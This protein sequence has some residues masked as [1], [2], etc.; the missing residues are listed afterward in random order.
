[1]IGAD[2]KLS[3]E[4]EIVLLTTIRDEKSSGLWFSYHD[5]E[6][7]YLSTSIY[8]ELFHYSRLIR[9]F[10]ILLKYSTYRYIL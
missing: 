8:L 7:L 2:N 10:L 1:M 5:F 6:K 9:F 3:P 4:E